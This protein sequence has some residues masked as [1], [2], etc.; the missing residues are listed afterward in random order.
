MEL[1]HIDLCGPIIVQSRGGKKYIFVIVDDYLRFTCTMF[2][3]SK[4]QTCEVFVIFIRMIQA[5]LNYK[6]AGIRLDHGIKFENAKIDI[7]C[8]KMVFIIISQPLELPNKMEWWI[9]IT[10]SWW[11]LLEL[12]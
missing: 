5:K 8:A 2:L 11:I 4:D 10:E 1:I 6:L 12:C 7:F 3:R 9:G